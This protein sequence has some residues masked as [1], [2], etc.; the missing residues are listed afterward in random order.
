MK[1][2]FLVPTAKT[3]V[4]SAIATLGLPGGAVGKAYISA[5]FIGHA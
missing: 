5:P 2:S 4:K 1:K 3:Y